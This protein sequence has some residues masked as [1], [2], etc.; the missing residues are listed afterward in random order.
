MRLRH[1]SV[2]FCKH[3][4][5]MRRLGVL[6][7]LLA[8]TAS[9]CRWGPWPPS[10]LPSCYPHTRCDRLDPEPV[11]AEP[12]AGSRSYRVWGTICVP[13]DDRQCLDVDGYIEPSSQPS[14]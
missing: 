11:P 1:L 9:C 4:R 13:S 14:Q 12:D 2:M 7:I 3:R 5:T 6:L 10:W 8:I